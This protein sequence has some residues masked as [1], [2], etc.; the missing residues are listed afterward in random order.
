MLFRNQIRMIAVGIC[1]GIAA[2]AGEISGGALGMNTHFMHPVDDFPFL[3]KELSGM[4]E[5]GATWLR[6]DFH[7]NK[8]ETQ[9]GTLDFQRTD[10]V[11]SAAK[12][13]DIQILGLLIGS[14]NSI[15][16]RL[17]PVSLHPAELD[18]YVRDVVR[19]YKGQIKYWEISNEEDSGGP[20]VTLVETKDPA[21][22]MKILRICSKA[23]R[24]TDPDAVVM[25]GG[26]TAPGC[27][28]LPFPYL[29]QLFA[30]G[31]AKDCDIISIHP[32]P[33]DNDPE[34][35]YPDRFAKLRKLQKQ[36]HAEHMPVWGT[37]FGESSGP[38]IEWQ[39]FFPAALQA[40]GI[41]PEKATLAVVSDPEW[42]FYSENRYVNRTKC[43]VKFRSVR[44]IKLADLAGLGNDTVLLW[45]SSGDF[46]PQFFPALRDF[47]QRGGCVV[48]PR[49]FPLYVETFRKPDGTLALTEKQVGSK[50]MKDLHIGWDAYWTASIPRTLKK[51]EGPG[52]SGCSLVGRVL[53][54]RNLQ[55]N[56]KFI[57]L[58]NALDSGTP[59]PVGGVYSFDSDFKGKVIMTTAWGLGARNRTTAEAGIDMPRQLLL[60]RALGEDKSF[61][62]KV[63]AYPHQ[64]DHTYGIFD[65]EIR[66]LPAATGVA[67]VMTVFP[68]GTKMS[69][70]RAGAPWIIRGERPDGKI[71]WAI[72]NRI[73]ELK[74]R[75]EYNV[76][77]QSAYDSQGNPL[78]IS[79]DKEIT[80]T[81]A[82][83][84]IVG[85][86]TL[87][88][89]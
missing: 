87:T 46:P 67:T 83:I 71:A 75:L 39:K 28:L 56:D 37:E 45:N 29:E 88:V 32:Y 10:A 13:H 55:G 33:L 49:G 21:V 44:E 19:H 26:L 64:V 43:G 72:W 52:F 84:Y 5:I 15:P 27:D 60:L 25:L 20:S 86:E 23:I 89:E 62:Y 61:I 8:Q 73:G 2:A 34:V 79:P 57:P 54:D 41:D 24:E 63:R 48:F 58:V 35:I 7:W 17:R 78:A 3:E 4:R 66:P 22:Y 82:P 9:P 12:K 70:F 47:I 74:T 42:S 76:K 51:V 6:V 53:S 80:V 16:E 11:V 50:Y 38:V 68:D 81:E 1:W 31:L 77:P 14:L 69:V 85:P 40:A 59:L 18:A 30:D 36:Y 65:P